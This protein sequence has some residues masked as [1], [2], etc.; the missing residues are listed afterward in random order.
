MS[1]TEQFQR[2]AL[3]GRLIFWVLAAIIIL[4]ILF[5]ITRF[6]KSKGTE[7]RFEI[8]E[9]DSLWECPSCNT[10]NK[11]TTFRCQNCGYKIE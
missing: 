7:N 2:G 5:I 11:N 3:E 10:E 4:A 1:P 6:K 9:P 8:E